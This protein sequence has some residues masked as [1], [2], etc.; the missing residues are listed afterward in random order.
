MNRVRTYIL[1]V[2]LLS[3]YISATHIHPN[4][5]FHVHSDC[6]VCVIAKNVKDSD[7]S[8]PTPSPC[9]TFQRNELASNSTKNTPLFNLKG[10][11]AT[12]PPFV[13]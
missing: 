6:K 10:F 11:D 4:D 1:F 9:F 5:P 12:A 7:L 13:I 8:L 2:F 3:S